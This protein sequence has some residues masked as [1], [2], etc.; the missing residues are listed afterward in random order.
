[1]YDVWGMAISPPELDSKDRIRVPLLS[2]NSKA[3]MYLPDNFNAAKAICEEVRQH[4]SLYW[5]MTVRWT[6]HISQCDSCILYPHIANTV[7]KTTMEHTRAI[8]LNIDA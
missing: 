1:M 5:L 3:F 8:D 4:G 6:V 2:I 7:L